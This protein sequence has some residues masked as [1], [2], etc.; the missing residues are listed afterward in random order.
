MSRILVVDDAPEVRRVVRRLLEGASFEIETAGTAAEALSCLDSRPV[1]LILLDLQLPDQSGTELCRDL[2]RRG[3]DVPIVMLTAYDSAL[4]R[5]RG[6]SCGADDYMGKPF[7]GEELVA[8]VRAQLRRTAMEAVRV[9][10]HLRQQW[11]LIHEGM[12]LA[13]AAQQPFARCSDA[14]LS[15]AVRYFPI[16]RVGGDFYLF[17]R[18]DERRSVLLIG[19]AMGHGVGSSLVMA[20][21]LALLAQLVREFD[22]PAQVLERANHLLTPDLKGLALFVSAFCGI[23]DRAAGAFRYSS[24][25][26]E[27]PLWVRRN[28]CGPGRRHQLLSTPGIVLGASPWGGY[29]EDVILPQPGD[30]LFFYTDGF[31]Q[32]VPVEDRPLLFRRLYRLLLETLDHPLEQ[33]AEELLDLL[34]CSGDGPLFLRDDLTFLVAEVP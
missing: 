31:T 27:S 22:S 25:G 13:Q 12:Q 29:S 23:W 1:D 19:D 16:G 7:N 2:R 14:G 28:H 17:Q 20:S 9:E 21:T 24:A 11:E 18:L 5:A 34:R 6:L 3:C 10:R 32:A 33:Q 26:H 8:R 4:D 30:R 15:T